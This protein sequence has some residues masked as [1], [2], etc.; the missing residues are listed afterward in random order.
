MSFP[1]IEGVRWTHTDSPEDMWEDKEFTI[2]DDGTVTWD[3]NDRL[4]PT[5]IVRVWDRRGRPVDSAAQE[6]A[7]AEDIREF[8][9]RAREAARNRSAEAEAEMRHEMRAAFGPGEEV[10][11][12]IT[13][14]RFVT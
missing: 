3:S 1:T 7:R 9:E 4:V 2:H 8:R 14:E 11:N 12:V 5:D 10:V 13:G 6:E